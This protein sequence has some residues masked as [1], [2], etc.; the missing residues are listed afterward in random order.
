MSLVSFM[1]TK[2]GLSDD[3]RDEQGG[4]P[5]SSDTDEMLSEPVVVALYQNLDH[6]VV[7]LIAV[8]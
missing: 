7:M 8:A 2:D 6:R 4:E 5:S 1:T 3:K